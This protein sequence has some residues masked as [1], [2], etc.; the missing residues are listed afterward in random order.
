[1]VPGVPSPP[2]SGKAYV[3]DLT[4]LGGA[5]ERHRAPHLLLPTYGAISRS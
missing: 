3:D 5:C 2:T 1:M 4:G